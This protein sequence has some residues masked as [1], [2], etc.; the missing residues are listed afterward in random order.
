M[1]LH[2]PLVALDSEEFGARSTKCSML[3]ARWIF[4]KGGHQAQLGEKCQ[5]KTHVYLR[6]FLM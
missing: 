4:C 2:T 3:G 5:G 6:M 1:V